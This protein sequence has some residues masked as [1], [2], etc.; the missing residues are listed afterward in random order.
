ME[1]PNWAQYA[2]FGVL[3]LA[4]FGAAGYA[5]HRQGEARQE[6]HRMHTHT[7]VMQPGD[8]VWG[9]SL[10]YVS[11]PDRYFREDVMRE[12]LER[13]P[14][15]KDTRKVPVAAGINVLCDGGAKCPDRQKP[16]N[17]NAK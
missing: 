15:I 3:G 14:R 6:L 9:H 10:M 16:K 8:T 7:Y 1:L 17:A 4:S 13:N 5:A 2:L 12:T 11:D